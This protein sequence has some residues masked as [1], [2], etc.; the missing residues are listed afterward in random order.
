MGVN[1]LW[2]LLTPAGRRIPIS[3]LS[4]KVL[5]IDASIWLVQFVKAMRDQDGKMIANAHILGTFRRLCRLLF[6]RVRPVFVFDGGTPAIKY[7]TL[8]ARRQ[9][10]GKAEFNAHRTAQKLLLNQLKRDRLNQQKNSSVD[11]ES[12]AVE[13]FVIPEDHR[14]DD[15][16]VS[17][18]DV[19]KSKAVQQFNDS[20]TTS[21]TTTTTK[22]QD[23]GRK[24]IIEL[25]SGSSNE[26]FQSS[27][28][29]LSDGGATVQ[30]GSGA[31]AISATTTRRLRKR[32]S[33]INKKRRR[34]RRKEYA[35]TSIS[36]I[37]GNVA[38]AKVDA[39]TSI[40]DDRNLWYESEDL[41]AGLDANVL[42]FKS[43]KSLPELAQMKAI[44]SA[45]RQ[46]IIVA[47]QQYRSLHG[48][49]SKFSNVQ[50]GNFIKSAHFNV[51]VEQHVKSLKPDDSA[52]KRIE[53][54][55]TREYVLTKVT[56]QGIKSPEK[57]IATLDVARHPQ[58]ISLDCGEKNGSGSR[59]HISEDKIKVY[60]PK[61]I[62]KN[63][64]EG[65]IA[66]QNIGLT[67]DDRIRRFVRGKKV[68][69]SNRGSLTVEKQQVAKDVLE[70]NGQ[71][72]DA[73]ASWGNSND[74]HDS[75]HEE[76]ATD[77]INDGWDDDVSDDNDEG[78]FD[79]GNSP[80]K[81]SVSQS[82]KQMPREE[83]EI[84]GV[85]HLDSAK[86][87]NLHAAAKLVTDV[88][89]PNEN[90]S[91]RSTCGH[92]QKPASVLKNVVCAKNSVQE[93][94]V[95]MALPPTC[96]EPQTVT[97]VTASTSKVLD[98]DVSNQIKPKVVDNI[99]S[100]TTSQEI[101]T[102]EVPDSP[103]VID[104]SQ[105][106]VSDQY[107]IK[108]KVTDASFLVDDTRQ[109]DVLSINASNVVNSATKTKENLD[110]STSDKKL[111][112]NSKDAGRSRHTSQFDK[113]LPQSREIANAQQ[114]DESRYPRT[115]ND[116][117]QSQK[118]NLVDVVGDIV[119][120]SE[121]LTN[122]KGPMNQSGINLDEQLSQLTANDRE[123]RKAH[124]RAI[125]DADGVTDEMVDDVIELLGLFGLPYVIAP[126]EAEAQCAELEK[127]GLVN[128]I[129]T[130]D[131]DVFVF[132]GRH[133]YKNFFEER[134]YTE[135]YDSKTLEDN[136]GFDQ[137]TFIAIA[138]LLGSDYA[139]GIKGVGIVNATEI[140]AAFGGT[141]NG[142]K[143]F[144]RWLETVDEFD[145]RSKALSK[146]E[147]KKMSQKDQFRY[148]HRK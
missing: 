87:N 4:D 139:I 19:D 111:L 29:E 131:S 76:S 49:P 15:R 42:D 109:S 132:G 73:S 89:Y 43:L 68:G 91:R 54:D 124:N 37:S 24:R 60:V 71:C 147:I 119:P 39:P 32:K 136:F 25:S 46:S 48:G 122:K 135:I 84:E 17:K 2:Q 92:Q 10:R 115:L 59:A 83:I 141:Q 3:T 144:K 41:Y 116:A 88:A 26:S 40:E 106:T 118:L 9:V 53:G 82:A 23:N 123:L 66:M 77:T 58:V 126:M 85:T 67:I 61:S 125:R 5:A 50:M 96:G 134:K 16:R 1:G 52:G 57:N 45:K 97:A 137:G 78:F 90:I 64:H 51:K 63:L 138:Q 105:T 36:S 143:E 7:R 98:V 110:L 8:R 81:F 20:V 31:R 72:S 11:K 65:K 35:M 34:K 94:D 101:R 121:T 47:Q 104:L 120:T 33:G 103:Q 128:G 117:H 13:G 99:E 79:V 38:G 127:L 108:P 145:R 95:P 130:N 21:T 44:Q 142:L 75:D 133:V 80:R 86:S 129:I 148:K 93:K 14:Y 140:I 100:D 28:S 69:E 12:A 55:D 74:S 62:R 56:D 30:D 18:I 107:M 22:S 6:H 146:S 27:D 102:P 114:N 112:I 113:Q 70:D